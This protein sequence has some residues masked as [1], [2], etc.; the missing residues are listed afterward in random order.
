MRILCLIAAL[1]A[2]GC[3]SSGG[4]APAAGQAAFCPECSKFCGAG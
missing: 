1:A 4:G 2:A 3:S